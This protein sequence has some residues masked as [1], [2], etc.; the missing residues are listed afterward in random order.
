MAYPSDLALDEVN[1]DDSLEALLTPNI[2]K[3]IRQYIRTLPFRSARF[4]ASQACPP[5]DSRFHI[6]CL[7]T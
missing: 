1:N 3:K 5:S 2:K 6:L 7:M 4:E